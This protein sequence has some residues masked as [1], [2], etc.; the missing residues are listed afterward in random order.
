MLKSKDSFSIAFINKCLKSNNIANMIEKNYFEEKSNNLFDEIKNKYDAAKVLLNGTKSLKQD[1]ENIELI[2]E[3]LDAIKNL[4][5]F[6]KPLLGKGNESDR[7]TRFYAEFEKLW[8]ELDEITPLYN[9]VRNYITQKPYS[10]EKFKLNFKN[11]TLLDGWD[12]NKEHDNSGII[13]RKDNLYYLAISSISDKPP[14]N[15]L[16]CENVNID[17]KDTYYEKMC[18]KF[19]DAPKTLHHV[20][21]SEKRAE[22]FNTPKQFIEN[23][24][25][26]AYKKNNYRELINFFKSSIDKHSGWKEFKFNFQDTNT[27]KNLNDFYKDFNQQGYKITFCNIP[28]KC[29]DKLVEEGKIYLFQIYNKD[30]SSYSK[31]KPNMHTLYWRMLFDEQNLKNVVYKLNGRA[32]IFFR[33]RSIKDE[34]KVIHFANKWLNNKNKENKKKQSCFNYNIIK[35]KRYTLDKFKFH[36][37]ITLNFKK[38]GN[39]NI[40]EKVNEYIK[41][42]HIQHIIGIDRG[43]RH[44][45]YLSVIDLN[46]KIIEQFSLNEIINQYKG[47]EYKT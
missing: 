28:E 41:E 44:L 39:I 19:L 40:N 31:G 2:K 14:K 46:N 17:K 20:F 10:V 30:F 33:K 3:F 16:E 15:F 26:K 36:V 13:L 9:K 18:Y 6:V 45:L 4:Q 11:S 1:K 7:D 43:E 34:N 29:I 27:Y 24:K 38:T 32:E 47:N 23:C 8:K 25:N 22:E 5:K 37:P 21:F 35:D 42:N 12:V